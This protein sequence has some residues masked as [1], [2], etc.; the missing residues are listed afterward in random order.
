MSLDVINKALKPLANKAK[1]MVGRCILSAAKASGLLVMQISALEGETIEGAERIENYGLAGHPPGGAE[2]VMCSV[3]GSR[4]HVV[5]V[6]M[7]HRGVRPE[8]DD[9]EV[10]LYSKFEQFIYLDKEG[11]I[12]IKAPK[13]IK[14]EAESFDAQITEGIVM[15]SQS[16]GITAPGGSTVDGNLSSTGEVQDHTNTMQNMREAYNPHTHPGVGPPSNSMG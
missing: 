3:G 4:D 5:I 16:L 2:G 6:A 7:E 14:I 10:K 13:G 9:G 8:I 11:N 12:I 15:N 1:L